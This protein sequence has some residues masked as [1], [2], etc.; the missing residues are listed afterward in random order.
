MNRWWF[1]WRPVYA[2]FASKRFGPLRGIAW[3]RWVQWEWSEQFNGL[4]RVHKPRYFVPE[5]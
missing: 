1:A 5:R 2:V 4:Y 3:M